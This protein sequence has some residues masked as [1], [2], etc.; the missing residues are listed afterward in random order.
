MTV[1]MEVF[2]ATFT[3]RYPDVQRDDVWPMTGEV[4]PDL[5]ADE[6]KALVRSLRH[7]LV[8]NLVY[9][10]GVIATT[11]NGTLTVEMTWRSSVDGPSI[12]FEAEVYAQL[13]TPAVLRGLYLV[14]PDR[15][16]HE[17]PEETQSS[18]V[19]SG[20]AEWSARGAPGY[21][22]EELIG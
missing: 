22:P 6:D 2:L 5:T 1:S 12:K 19:S 17:R 14:I 13:C 16:P 21:T 11:T 20:F 10:G 9:E 3:Q 8:M 15:V 18:G 7:G 4:Y